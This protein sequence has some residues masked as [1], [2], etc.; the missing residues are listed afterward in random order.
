[1]WYRFEQNKWYDSGSM[2]AVMPAT[3]EYTHLGISGLLTPEFII[4]DMYETISGLVYC[5]SPPCTVWTLLQILKWLSSNYVDNTISTGRGGYLWSTLKQLLCSLLS[6]QLNWQLSLPTHSVITLVQVQTV[7]LWPWEIIA[8]CVCFNWTVYSSHSIAKCRAIT[9]LPGGWPRYA[10]K[11]MY[12]V[13]HIIFIYATPLERYFKFTQ[14][15]TPPITI[16]SLVL[17]WRCMVTYY[18]MR[19]L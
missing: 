12:I 6:W 16:L 19:V 8:V 9:V 14:T 5:F 10:K 4:L 17:W 3:I 13:L 18:H 1:M 7:T 11:L 15:Y 2:M